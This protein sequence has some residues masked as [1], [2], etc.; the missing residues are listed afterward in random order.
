MHININSTVGKT[1]DKNV[2]LRKIAKRIIT[3]VDKLMNSFLMICLFIYE[4]IINK[5]KRKK[6]KGA[7]P[8]IPIEH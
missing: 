5:K 4:I 7:F 6:K 1:C 8:Q 2:V 3:F